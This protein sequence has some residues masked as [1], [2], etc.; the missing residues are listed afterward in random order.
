M[1]SKAS[2]RGSL[3]LVAVVFIPKATS[4][5]W[6]ARA[7]LPATVPLPD[8][9]FNVGTAAG[10]S[11]GLLT[12]NRVAIAAGMHD[13]LHEPYRSRLFPHLTPMAEAL[14]S[15]LSHGSVVVVHRDV[16]RAK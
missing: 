11:V 7:A 9:A 12:R 1:L 14:G 3:G 2:E 6:A 15:K 10:L 5:T 4:A 13:R 16:E 8:A